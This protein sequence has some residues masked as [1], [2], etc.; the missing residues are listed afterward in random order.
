MRAAGDQTSVAEG[1]GKLARIAYK[2]VGVLVGVLG[3]LVAGAVFKRIWAVAADESGPPEATEER[4]GWGEVAV[5]AA[6]QGAIHGVVRAL[7]QRGGA[8]TFA[9]VTGAWPGPKT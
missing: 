6:A 7:I 2:P 9:R 5:A 1:S 8:A 4:R 3:G